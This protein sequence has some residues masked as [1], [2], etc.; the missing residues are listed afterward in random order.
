MSDR[1]SAGSESGKQESAKLEPDAS[2]SEATVDYSDAETRIGESTQIGPYRLMERIGEG[3][4]GVIYVAE[5]SEPVR[6][7]VAVKVIKPGAD[8]KEVIARFNAERQALAMMD[9]PNIARVFDAGMTEQ[10]RPYFVMELVRGVPITQFCDKHKLGSRA[11]LELFI[12]VCHAIQHAHQKGII[13]RDVKPTNVLVASHDGKPVVKVIDFGVAKAINQRLTDQTVYTRYSQ[14]VGTPMYM[15]PEQAE[16]T[17]LDIDTRSDIYSLGVLLYELLTGG[18]PFDRKRLKKLPYDEMRRVLREEDPPRPSTRISTLGETAETVSQRRGT[19]AKRLSLLLR[20]DLDWI[21]M[22]A[23]EKDRT[24]RYETANGFALDV[25]RHLH[26]EPVLASPPSTLYRAGKLVQRNRGAFTAVAASILIL[27]VGVI[28]TSYGMLS[29]LQA[30]SVIQS[31]NERLDQSNRQL[32]AAYEQIQLANRNLEASN[33]REAA[34]RNRAE[35]VKEFLVGAFRKADPTLEGERLTVVEVLRRSAAEMEADLADD[36]R[37]RADLLAAIGNSYLGLGLYKHAREI[38]ANEQELR[39]TLDPPE[40]RLRL[41]ADH[42]FAVTL[43]HNGE[44]EQAVTE[45]ESL[46]KRQQAALGEQD[47]ET[48]TTLSSLADCFMAISRPQEALELYQQVLAGRIAA[49]GDDDTATMTAVAELASAHQKMGDFDKAL[50]LAA[51]NLQRHQDVFGETHP[52]TLGAIGRLA[53]IHQAKGDFKTAIS[54][55]QR[56]WRMRDTKLGPNHPLTLSSKTGL[57]MVLRDDGQLEEALRVLEE[58]LAVKR[59]EL[60]EDNHATLA[61]ANNVVRVYLELG[62]YDDALPLS[63]LCVAK[64][65]MLLGEKSQK[66]IDA[67]N[68]LGMTYFYADRTADALPV[69]TELLAIHEDVYGVEH[70]TTMTILNNLAITHQ[71]EGQLEKALP[72]MERGFDW[73]RENLGEDHPKTLVSQQNLASCLRGLG[74]LKESIA[75]SESTVKLHKQKLGV[76]HRQTLSAMSAL[77]NAYVQHGDYDRALTLARETFAAAETAMGEDHPDTL[78]AMN[79][80]GI[81]ALG[82][83][84]VDEANEMFA[85]TLKR[86]RK[87]LGDAHSFTIQSM[88]NLAAGLITAKETDRALQTAQQA[89]DAAE[90]SLKPDDSVTLNAQETLARAKLQAGENEQAKVLLEKAVAGRE[91]S[92]GSQ[93]PNLWKAQHFLGQAL[94]ELG[95]SAAATELVAQVALQRAERFGPENTSTLSSQLLLA[96]CQLAARQ[97]PEAEATLKAV[98][99]QVDSYGDDSMPSRRQRRQRAIERWVA[100]YDAWEKPDEAA[101]WRSELAMDTP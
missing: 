79:S 57:G 14:V 43:Y 85:D 8:T 24:R 72:L 52:R 31:Q 4:M 77:A 15:S 73:R 97:F 83:G 37:T 10:G 64:S 60:G 81:A 94:L 19:D 39:A 2:H 67:L 7:R 80:I 74:R 65:R 50:A 87:K 95:E 26:N 66:T 13:H 48:F 75:M 30:K 20:G 59:E 86:R 32:A 18:T 41:R 5:Q 16:M 91:R 92:L 84:R 35:R 36:P 88:S 90:T 42:S 51:R 53:S 27:I 93:H 98:W 99:K 23:M 28:G 45:L 70:P 17:G 71:F 100:L 58:V 96:K 12:D 38:F 55:Y 54:H 78:R 44:Y 89:L 46:L 49:A 101:R 61:A 9:H 34:A 76:E 40:E 21:V 29:A 56:A 68:S 1:Q 22:K 25:K 82:A 3:G 62:R 33:R 69:F 63:E 11:R 6:R 47:P